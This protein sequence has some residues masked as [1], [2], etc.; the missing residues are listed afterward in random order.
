MK[1]KMPEELGSKVR[2]LVISKTKNSD[3]YDEM[4][5]K[6]KFNSDDDLPLK[7]MLE[8]HT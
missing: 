6:I 5:K 1:V 7:K 4:Y 2:D 8:L 3:D